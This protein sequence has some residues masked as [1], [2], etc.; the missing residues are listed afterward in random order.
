M[1]RVRGVAL[2]MAL[3]GTSVPAF[4]QVNAPAAALPAERDPAA[5]ATAR[6]II[7]LGYPEE[8][9]L[10][11]FSGVLD[12]LVGQMKSAVMS[13]LDNDPGAKAIV[14][15]SVD[16][17]LQS[18][19]G[20]LAKH[21]PAFMDAYA[22]AYSREFTP[23]E[24]DEILAFVKTPAGAH[25]FSRSP[26]MMADPA[27]AAANTAYMRELEPLIGQMREQMLKELMAYLAAHPPKPS[28]ES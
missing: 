19:K 2:L 24:L 18:S 1:R 11:M 27:V 13:Q 7:R 14:E 26:S 16:R 15:H 12:T 6:E 22:Q 28:G 10:A 23:A 21:I 8:R 3:A 9:R 4:A 17:T 20:V 25:F 5:L